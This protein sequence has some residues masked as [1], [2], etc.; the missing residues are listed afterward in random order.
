MLPCRRDLVSTVQYRMPRSILWLVVLLTVFWGINWPA[1]KIVLLEMAPLHF[2][3]WCLF[4]GCGTLFAMSIL[5]GLT[6]RVPRGAWT[7]LVTISIVNVCGWNAFAA[8]GVPLMDSGRA[9]ILGYTFPIWCVPLSVWLL[10]EPLTRSRAW[11]LAIG[12]AGLALLLGGEFAAVGRSPLGALLMLGAALSW[13]IGIVMIKRWP[14]AMP[15]TSFAAW[16]MAIALVPVAGVALWVEPGSFSPAALSRVGLLSFLYN[17]FVST[18]FCFWAWM[19]IVAVAP[20]A[21]SSLSTLMIPVIGVFSGMLV[22]GEHPQ[23]NDFAALVLVVA[24]LVV[25]LMPPR[26]SAGTAQ[27]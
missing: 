16:Q 25:V 5:G 20:A 3:T 24:S 11:G 18:A 27:V 7:R 19:R 13:A 23:W 1:M 10:K 6:L 9:S 8:Y 21:V 4:A 17:L 22:L 12:T 2:R 26:V 15:T 14:V